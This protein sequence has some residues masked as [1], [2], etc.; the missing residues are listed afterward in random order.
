MNRVLP[1]GD[2]GDRSADSGRASGSRG[3]VL[4][5]VGLVCR[6]AAAGK[7]EIRHGTP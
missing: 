4:S 1:P 5:F 3:I 2:R 6:V 7:E